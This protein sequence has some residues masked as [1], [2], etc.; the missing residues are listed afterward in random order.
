MVYDEWDVG[1]ARD[2]VLDDWFTRQ[3]VPA[4]GHVHQRGVLVL[5]GGRGSGKS[6][7]LTRFEERAANTHAVRVDCEQLPE[8][9]R[10][11]V[12]VLARI[13]F[14]LSATVPALPPL[15][16]PAYATL[17]LA[18]AVRTDRADRE[19]ALGELSAAL[20]DGRGR[21]QS[22]DL[23][24]SLAEKLGSVAGM[25]TLGLAALPFL[26]EGLK[27]WQRHRIRRA[28]LRHVDAPASPEDFLV[29]LGHGFQHGDDQQR[30]RAQ[31]V[32]TRAFLDDLR[33]AY[34]TGRGSELRTLRSLLLLDNADDERGQ[35]FLETLRAA[36]RHGP[37]DGDPLVVVATA[38]ERPR[39]VEP[40]NVP[41]G[42]LLTCWSSQIVEPGPARTGGVDAEEE[43][44]EPLEVRGKPHLRVA[45]LRT[46]NRAEVAEQC[47]PLVDRL[48]A[49]AGVDRPADWLGRIV[50]DLTGGHPFATAETLRELLQF[51]DQVPV[52]TR[53]RKLYS[54]TRDR[55]SVAE[56]A[57]RRMF[58]DVPNAVRAP[59]PRVA[60]AAVPVQALAADAL[61][62]RGSHQLFQVTE[63][64]GDELRCDVQ[65]VDGGDILL[66]P[67]IARRH[68][69]QRLAQSDTGA[70]AG[71]WTGAHRRLRDS[72]R[73]RD[74]AYH[75]LALG[76]VPAATRYLHDLLEQVKDGRAGMPRWCRALSWVQRA[77]HPRLCTPGDGRE[78]Y[79]AGVARLGNRV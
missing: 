20:D 5:L 79:E 29:G 28:L 17:R 8:S 6:G 60:A 52:V 24:V 12:D 74:A 34:G 1:S 11:P 9:V 53:L 15:Q 43:R 66:L 70:E 2:L 41:A 36:R 14:G 27:R 35:A 62:G 39:L 48:P 75:Q 23:F 56:A 13:V 77:P 37:P 72:V 73:D 58:G 7:V 51:D 21:E 33:R 47:R 26:S 78:E 63:L 30:R 4:P 57:Y 65:A 19:A 54:L 64:I 55:S 68:L 67:P 3:L 16:L 18:L 46:L 59:L 40:L 22:L 25:P 50:H 45:Q 42:R 76:D 38:R 10:N 31:E 61:W 71:T 49:T 69:L 44:F 32:L